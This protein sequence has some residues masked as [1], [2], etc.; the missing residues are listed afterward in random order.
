MRDG[1]G[2]SFRAFAAASLTLAEV[3]RL[4]RSAR[5]ALYRDIATKR[6]RTV[7]GEIAK[8]PVAPAIVRLLGATKW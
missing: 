8:M 3:E 1:R 7:L 4:D 6:R 2:A 5:F